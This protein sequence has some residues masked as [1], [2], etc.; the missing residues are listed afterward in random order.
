MSGPGFIHL[1][2]HSA[3]SLLEGA[4]KLGKL[5]D[6]AKADRQPAIGIADTNNLFGALEFSEKAAG[7]GIQPLLGAELALD[8]ETPAERMLERGH[9]RGS[10]GKSAVVLMAANEEGY[11]NLSRL[12]SRAY[13]EGEAGRAAAQLGWLDRDSLAGVIC[14]TGGPEGAIDPWF[15]AGLD[16]QAENRLET[17]RN[18]FGDRFY[19]EIQRHGLASEHAN[20]AR[21]I[22]YAYRRGVPLVATNEPF[23]PAAPTTRRMTRCSPSPPARCGADRAAQAHPEHYSS[24]AP[25]WSSCSRTCRRRSTIRS[26]SRGASATGRTRADPSCRASPPRRTRPP[27]GHGGRGRAAARRGA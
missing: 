24:R 22:D 27:G 3:Y 17:L 9:E 2:I 13:L 18:L 14:L 6:L 11:A 8:F 21:L 15:A 26:R 10:F 1:H 5:L 16:G 25:K 12:V 4:L 7:K 20:E 23:L 19:V